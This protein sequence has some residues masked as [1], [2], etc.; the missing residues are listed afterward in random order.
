MLARRQCPVVFDPPEKKRVGSVSARKAA[1]EVKIRKSGLRSSEGCTQNL[2]F[3]L[4]TTKHGAEEIRARWG[5]VQKSRSP[6]PG[7]SETRKASRNRRF[8]PHPWPPDLGGKRTAPVERELLPLIMKLCSLRPRTGF[9]RRAR[10]RGAPEKRHGW[11]AGP[12]RGAGRKVRVP[13]TA[14]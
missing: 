6:P 1:D 13:Q 9:R 7:R 10:E 14:G 3:R 4:E 12:T 8:Q 11:S 2:R 5:H